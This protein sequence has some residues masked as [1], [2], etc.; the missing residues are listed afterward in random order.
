MD[1]GLLEAVATEAASEI[2]CPN[3]TI[4][5]DAIPLYGKHCNKIE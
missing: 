2:I 3:A 5:A 1:P 4:R